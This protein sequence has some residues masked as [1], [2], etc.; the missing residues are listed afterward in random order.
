MELSHNN[1]SDVLVRHAVTDA[2]LQRQSQIGELRQ[3]HDM[4]P[5][6]MRQ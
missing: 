1:V 3:A 6:M 4:E 5:L 2:S